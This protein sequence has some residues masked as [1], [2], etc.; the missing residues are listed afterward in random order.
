LRLDVEATS[1]GFEGDR[2]LVRLILMHLVENGL[3]FTEHGQVRVSVGFDE[4][5]C[6]LTVVDSGPGIPRDQQARIFQPFEPSETVRR[7]HLPG[8]GLGLSLVRQLV[9]ALGGSITLTSRVGH[10]TK[11]SVRLPHRTGSA[12]ES[13]MNASA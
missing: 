11:F 9:D 2:E 1:A 13:P 5:S 3:K 10:G 4:R 12:L 6:R 8:I 7:K